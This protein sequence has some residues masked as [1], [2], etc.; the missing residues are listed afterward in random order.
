VQRRYETL[1][2][3]NQPYTCTQLLCVRV[4]VCLHAQSCLIILLQFFRLDVLYECPDG[5]L[6]MAP[7]SHIIEQLYNIIKMSSDPSDSPVGILT[8]D[9]RDTWAKSRERLVA[10]QCMVDLT[11]TCVMHMYSSTLYHALYVN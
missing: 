4:R 2:I 6:A 7:S 9:H 1:D 10:G 3:V 8:S 5:T 11:Y